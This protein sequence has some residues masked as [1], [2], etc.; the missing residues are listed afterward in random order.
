MKVQTAETVP[1]K[2]RIRQPAVPTA[3]PLIPQR[4]SYSKLVAAAKACRACPLWRRATQTV[5]GE[6]ASKAKVMVVGEQ[7]GCDEDIDGKPFVGPAGRVLNDGLVSA[8]S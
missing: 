8:G 2:R 1:A 5:L 7:P 3:A 4:A 6:G